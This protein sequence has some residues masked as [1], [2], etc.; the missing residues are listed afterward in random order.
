M[1]RGLLAKLGLWVSGGLP[2]RRSFDRQQVALPVVLRVDGTPHVCRIAD[3]SPTGAFLVPH[4]GI[5]V[6]AN[7]ALEL[8]HTA[9][10]ADL[11]IVRRTE[12]GLGVSFHKDGI[13]AIVAGW[14][15]GQTPNPS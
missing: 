10:K 8:P 4:H 7:G 1:I 2:N 14:L 6:G 3:V 9:I 13:G 11:T 15:Q 5:E 12:K